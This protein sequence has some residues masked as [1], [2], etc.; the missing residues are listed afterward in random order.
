MS[1][2][3]KYKDVTIGNGY[4]LDINKFGCD[5]GY[6][7]IGSLCMIEDIT[8]DKKGEITLELRSLKRNSA[9]PGSKGGIQREYGFTVPIDV[10][11]SCF[12]LVTI[13]FVVSKHFIIGTEDLNGL[14]GKVICPVYDYRNKKLDIMVEFDEQIQCG[15]CADGLGK[16]GHCLLI[17]S[18]VINIFI[19]GEMVED[20]NNILTTRQK[21]IIEINIEQEAHNK[22]RENDKGIRGGSVKFKIPFSR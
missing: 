1:D 21:E 16:H 14:T 3:F 11:L 22:R 8:R 10:A 5:S 17:P 18:E 7:P 20:V 9:W 4:F 19:N 12:N 15:G 13:K 6:G 2:I